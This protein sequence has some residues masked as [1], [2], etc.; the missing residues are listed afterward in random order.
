[1]SDCNAERVYPESTSRFNI[2]KVADRQDLTS[3]KSSSAHPAE[4][5]K[6]KDER[7]HSTASDFGKNS[8]SYDDDKERWDRQEYVRESHDEAIDTPHEVAGDEAHDGAD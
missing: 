1:V 4:H 7:R 3:D 8:R 2:F 5:D 6:D